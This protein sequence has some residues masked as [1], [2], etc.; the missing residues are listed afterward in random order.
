LRPAWAPDGTRIV[1]TRF[2]PTGKTARLDLCTMNPDGTG[3]KLLINMPKAFPNN[4]DWG[5]AP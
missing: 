5:T 2:T 4:A 3:L 1:F